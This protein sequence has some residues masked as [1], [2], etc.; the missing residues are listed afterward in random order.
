MGLIFNIENN[1]KFSTL[2]GLS[3]G[4]IFASAQQLEE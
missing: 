2:L 1:M 4:P 3:V